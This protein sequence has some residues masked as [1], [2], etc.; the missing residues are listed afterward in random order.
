MGLSAG[1]RPGFESPHGQSRVLNMS[2]GETQGS[3]TS[4]SGQIT[5]WQCLM[6]MLMD[7]CNPDLVKVEN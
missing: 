1:E 4:Q 6:L 7:L 2:P 3:I 5:H